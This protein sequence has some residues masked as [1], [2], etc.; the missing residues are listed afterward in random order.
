MTLYIHTEFAVALHVHPSW[1]YICSLLCYKVQ[2][3]FRKQGNSMYSV[4]Q[5]K[6]TADFTMFR[7]CHTVTGGHW[8]VA[9]LCTASL[10]R[11]QAYWNMVKCWSMQY[12]VISASEECHISWHP[13]VAGGGIQSTLNVREMGMV[14]CNALDSSRFP[15]AQVHWPQTAMCVM[16]TACAGKDRCINP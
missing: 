4:K 2:V 15:D 12:D 11:W 1:Y 13:F 3:G 8:G 6:P 10:E 16:Q 9:Y 7:V 14:Q 5:Y